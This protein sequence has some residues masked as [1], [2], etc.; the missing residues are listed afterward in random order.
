MYRSCRHR[1]H[2]PRGYRYA[3]SDGD[4]AKTTQLRL[5][6]GPAVE[7]GFPREETAQKCRTPESEC[8][9]SRSHTNYGDFRPTTTTLQTRELANRRTTI[10][11]FYHAPRCSFSSLASFFENPSG[12]VSFYSLPHRIYAIG[13]FIFSYPVPVGRLQRNRVNSLFT[14]AALVEPLAVHKKAPYLGYL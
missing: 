12:H 13:N 9:S 1:R 10:C 14:P 8:R 4:A 11:R 7:N 2:S 5:V 3:Q 6:R